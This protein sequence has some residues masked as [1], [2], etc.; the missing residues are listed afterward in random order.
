MKSKF[1]DL[2]ANDPEFEQHLEKCVYDRMQNL[3]NDRQLMD[4]YS[5]FGGEIFRRSSV[6]Y[7]LSDFLKENKVQGDTCLEIGTCHGLTAVVLARHFKHVYSVDIMPSD[8]KR[9]IIVQTGLENITFLD[10]KNNDEKAK[11]IKS[12]KFD[13]AFM[14]GDHA[15]DTDLDWALVKHCGRVLMHEAWK[16]QKPVWDL[17]K[18]LP[19]GQVKYGAFNMALWVKR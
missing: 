13:F 9:R 1:S 4:I 7:G 8:L 11:I 19:K 17:V 14:D 5:R 15:H 18:S 10:A 2:I 16:N 3:L 12:V 6:L